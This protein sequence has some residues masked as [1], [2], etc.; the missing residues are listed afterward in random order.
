MKEFIKKYLNFI[1]SDYQLTLIVRFS[2]KNCFDLEIYSCGIK[3]TYQNV[4]T[5]K[6]KFKHFKEAHHSTPQSVFERWVANQ[7]W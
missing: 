2:E 3:I 7:W 1:N 6:L 5:G 4:K